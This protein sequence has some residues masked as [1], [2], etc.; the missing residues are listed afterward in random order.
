M[1]A[2][3][4]LIGP[5]GYEE[6]LGAPALSYP[7]RPRTVLDVLD[8]AVRRFADRTFITAPEGEVS[9]GEFAELVEGAAERLGEEGVRRGDRLAVVGHNGLDLAVALFACARAGCVL[10]GLSTRAAPD[11]WAY[12]LDHSGASLALAQPPFVDHLVAGAAIAGLAPERVRPF[13]DHLTGR[14]RR[15]SYVPA[16]RPD[17]ADPYAVVYT[18]GT[19]GRPKASRVVHRASVHSGLS[20][21]A[22][23]GLGGDD[24]TA[25][26]FSLTYIS[27]VHAHLLPMLLVGGR[28]VL[29]PDARPAELVDLVARERVTWLYLV[30]ALWQRLLR[31]RALASPALDHLRVAGFGGSPMPLAT[32]AELRRRLPR[33]TLRDVY[34]L[35]ETHSPATILLDHEFAA[36]PGSVGRPLPCMEARVV[37]DDG[38]DLGPDQPGEL[39]VRGSLVTTGY[40]GD[41]E[42]TAA[43]IADGWFRTG[44]LARIDADGYVTILDRTKDMINRGGHKVFSAEVERVLREHPAVSDAAVVGV[45]DAAAGEAVAAFVVTTETGDGVEPAELRHWVRDHLA[46]YAAPRWVHLVAELPRN[47]TGKVLKTE[48]RASAAQLAG[49]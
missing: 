31:V 6:W 34:G 39:L 3:D 4:E 38:H 21:T 7:N 46:D 47:A 42:A 5:V 30:P 8:R 35:S 1:E 29:V 45:P 2:I 41:P 19:T 20:F 13:G 10:V 44:D 37:D 25:V 18:S 26:V 36:K 43:A 16:D 23:V 22:A 14:R 17:E 27:A 40:D 12:L 28:C 11:Q 32:I 24:V 33:L 48:L 15:W 9:F 49:R